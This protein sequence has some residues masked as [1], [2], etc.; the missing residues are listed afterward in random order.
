VAAT[1]ANGSLIGPSSLY[2]GSTTPAKPSETIVLYANGFGTTSSPV[3][4][5][6]AKQSGNLLPLPVIKIGGATA[7]VTFAGL[8]LPGEFQFNVVVPSALADGNQPIT[9]TYGGLSTQ[10]GTLIAIQH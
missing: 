4:S 2:P 7:M 10:A 8:V 5:G 9:A 6:S 3:V 1:H